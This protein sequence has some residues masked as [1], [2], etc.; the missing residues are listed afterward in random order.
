MFRVLL[1]LSLFLFTTGCLACFTPIGGEKYDALIKIEK[2]DTVNKYSFQIPYKVESNSDVVVTLGYAKDNEGDFKMMDERY[3][4]KT[5][6][7]GELITGTFTV[8]NNQMYPF[9]LVSWR[10]D[11][12][13][14]C[15]VVAISDFLVVN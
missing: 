1:S 2:L 13:G 14:M 5:T 6:R 8:K 15:S 9:L 3:E 11:L 10:A 7:N 4:L 12:N